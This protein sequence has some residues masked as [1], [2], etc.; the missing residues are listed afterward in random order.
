MFKNI[1]RIAI[2]IQILLA[3]SGLVIISYYSNWQT[4]L[5]ITLLLWANN[6]DYERKYD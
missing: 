3:I 1:I 4:A 5:G 2:I 6:F